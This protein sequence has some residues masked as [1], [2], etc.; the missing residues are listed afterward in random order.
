MGRVTK[1]DFCCPTLQDQSLS[2]N[3]WSEGSQRRPHLPASGKA[4]LKVSHFSVTTFWFL[5]KL[6]HEIKLGM[7]PESKV[8]TLLGK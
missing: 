1:S 2:K 4:G 7:W 3:V 5:K 6:K 8:N